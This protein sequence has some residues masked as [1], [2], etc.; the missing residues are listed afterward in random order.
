MN[1]FVLHKQ[2]CKAIITYGCKSNAQSGFNNFCRRYSVSDDATYARAMRK[3]CLE[4]R[5][6]FGNDSSAHTGGPRA[7]RAPRAVATLVEDS[8]DDVIRM[9]LADVSPIG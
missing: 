8:K 2:L 4:L 6:G 5:A 9:G 3:L 1:I 7:S